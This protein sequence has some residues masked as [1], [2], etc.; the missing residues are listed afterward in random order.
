[1]TAEKGAVSIQDALHITA[2]AAVGLYGFIPMGEFL[3]LFKE[4]NDAALSMDDMLPFLTSLGEQEHGYGLFENENDGFVVHAEFLAD[5]GLLDLDDYYY[6][7]SE[8]EPYRPGQKK[9]LKWAAYDSGADYEHTTQMQ[10]LLRHLT[11]DLGISPQNAH[12]ALVDLQSMATMGIL[13][14]CLSPSFLGTELT[15][16]VDANNKTM[17]LIASC[18]N[19]TRQ[20]RYAGH[21]PHE[22]GK[23]LTPEQLVELHEESFEWSK[24]KFEY[25]LDEEAQR[26]VNMTPEEQAVTFNDDFALCDEPLYTLAEIFDCYE[27]FQLA[28]TLDRMLM[29]TDAFDLPGVLSED[30]ASED[31]LGDWDGIIERLTE[32]LCN[33]DVLKNLLFTLSVETLEVFLQTVETSEFVREATIYPDYIEALHL[34]LIAPFVA[35]G[36]LILVVPNEVKET[37]KAVDKDDLLA[38]SKIWAALDDYATAAVW[39]YGAIGFDE[40]MPIFNAFNSVIAE[41]RLPFAILHYRAMS[42]FSEFFVTM[43]DDTPYL[44]NNEL[45]DEDKLIKEILDSLQD[46]E[47]YI[48]E[49]DEFARYVSG[50]YFEETPQ[51]EALRTFL[52]SGYAPDEDVTEAVLWEVNYS[53]LMGLPPSSAIEVYSD[54]DIEFES[55]ECLQLAIDL[56]S[57]VCNHTRTWK[58]KGHTPAEILGE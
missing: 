11:N 2:K 29:I 21:T 19:H 44:I 51:V 10:D 13:L 18:Y 41:S 53:V 38:A 37:W 35:D 24:E 28:M 49:K 14:D 30:A 40:F 31:F 42:E 7:A 58:N 5:D 48:P 8:Y 4:Q 34:G 55:Q 54:Y 39:L 43:V 23:G 50:E 45:I 26:I 56:T 16:D 6:P 36:K 1:M 20:W 46:K 12:N 47:R 3:S 52:N 25:L 33:P 9:F 27:D 22:V 32:L 57:D 17:Q 15:F